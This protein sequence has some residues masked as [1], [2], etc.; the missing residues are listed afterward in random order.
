M[1]IFCETLQWHDRFTI[2]LN[3][4]DDVIVVETSPA[5]KLMNCPILHGETVVRT[6]Y[7]VKAGKSSKEY[8]LGIRMIYTQKISMLKIGED[9]RRHYERRT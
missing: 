8:T 6:L 4:I 9:Y 3:G 2:S 7:I 5:V 1:I